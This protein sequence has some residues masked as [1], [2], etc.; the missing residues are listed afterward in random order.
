ME[1][2]LPTYQILKD[3]PKVLPM[4]YS[5][6]AQPAVKKVGQALETVFEFCNTILL[7]LK[8]VNEKAKLNFKKHMDKYKERIE[9]IEEDKI[10]DIPTIIGTPIIDRLTYVTNDEIAELFI[11]LLAKA[12]SSDTIN[13]AHPTF[14]HIIDRMTIDEARI[15]NHIVNVPDI[16]FINLISRRKGRSSE[17]KKLAWN[18]T[19]LEFDVELLCPKNIDTYLDNLASLRIIES[20]GTTFK[21]SETLYKTLEIK[22]VDVIKEWNDWAT[23]TDVYF[24]CEITKGYFEVTELGKAFIKT[25]NK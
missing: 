8:L 4:I 25:C 18:L 14:I 13:E 6:C 16:P 1:E 20:Q 9:G 15:I 21:T 2:N 24:T 17:Y 3:S 22:Y 5:D 10:V 12:S 11:N 23:S 7:P 19:G